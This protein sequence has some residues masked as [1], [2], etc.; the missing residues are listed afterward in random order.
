VLNRTFLRCCAGEPFEQ[1][2]ASEGGLTPPQVLQLS[3]GVKAPPPATDPKPEKIRKI[4]QGIRCDLLI[5]KGETWTRYVGKRQRDPQPVSL[6]HIRHDALRS[7]LWLDFLEMV[8][9]AQGLESTNLIPVLYVG[10][11]EDGFGV[12]SRFFPGAIS[13]RRL[14]DRVTRLKLSEA[15]R[16]TREIAQGLVALHEK[17]V[18]H[19]A[20]S[21]DNVVLT[22]EGRVLLR[23]AGIVWEAPGAPKMRGIYGELHYMAPECFRGVPPNPMSDIYAVGA[24]C[25]EMATGT[26]PFE[27]DDYNLLKHQH[28]QIPPCKPH[29]LLQDLPDSVSDLV[30]WLLGK[31]AKDRPDAPKLVNVLKTLERNIDRTGRTERFQAFGR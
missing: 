23:D 25:Y 17:G 5:E 29:E 22:R 1:V 14:L 12:V 10:R 3:Q 18:V 16:I 30:S 15:L 21:P 6:L 20:L 7:G 27:G 31:Q 9:A 8:R 2:L 19:R 4:V 28:E 26:R 11:D 24:M 13:L